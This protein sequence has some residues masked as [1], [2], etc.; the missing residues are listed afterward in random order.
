AMDIPDLSGVTDLSFTFSLSGIDIIPNIN[1]WDIS[2]VTDLSNMFEDVAGFNQSLD[3]WDVSDVTNMS[4]MFKGATS[5]NQ[6]LDSWDVRK[7]E[8]FQY[9]F[10]D[11]FSFNQSLA[12]WQLESFAAAVFAF[13][14]SGMSCEN[15]S[16]SLYSWATNP[17]TNHDAILGGSG[18]TYSPDVAPYVD[19]LRDERNW[20]F[21]L[22]EEGT[23]S[24]VLPDPPIEPG[25]N[26]ILYVDVNVNTAATG[27]TGVGDS[28][29][30][31]I[32]ELAD[33]L[34]WAR[35]QHD[36]GSPGW[37]EAEPLRIFVAKG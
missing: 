23:C 7:L 16:Y 32:P 22:L 31:A 35:E 2:N 6:P 21:Q 36:G 1:A 14:G 11:A 3:N 20:R 26:H 25:D 30:N 33:A 4:F 18:V 5:F 28:W 15:F 29:E 24:V 8:H 17:N 10:R 9:M 37:T 19:K 13:T 12:A 27:Y 34:K